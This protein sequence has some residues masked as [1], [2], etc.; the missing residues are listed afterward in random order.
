MSSTALYNVSLIGK[1]TQSKSYKLFPSTEII[2][3]G[4]QGQCLFSS[5]AIPSCP[6]GTYAAEQKTVTCPEKPS[7]GVSLTTCYQYYMCSQ[8]NPTSCPDI[9]GLKY[10]SAIPLVNEGEVSELVEIACTYYPKG[11]ITLKTY[12]TWVQW[13]GHDSTARGPLL[14]LLCSNSKNAK[15]QRCAGLIKSVT[16]SSGI[17]FSELIN[18]ALKQAKTNEGSILKEDLQVLKE[19]SGHKTNVGVIVIV[20][21]ALLVVLAAIILIIILIKR[22]KKKKVLN[23]PVK[24]VP[25]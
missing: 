13:F 10:S 21:V 18:E 20:V 25:I 4:K 12:D 3:C 8:I 22:H 5:A 1:T 19:V 16:T 7:A 9:S 2:G 6:T 24:K 17:N 15:L 11:E 23:T 14:K